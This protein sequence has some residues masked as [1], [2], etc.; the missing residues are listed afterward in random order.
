MNLLGLDDFVEITTNEI[1]EARTSQVKA[2]QT[3]ESRWATE[4]SAAKAAFNSSFFE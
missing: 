1:A 4:Y 2:A 3:Q